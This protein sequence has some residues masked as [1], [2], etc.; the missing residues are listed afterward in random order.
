MA[1]ET[2][3]YSEEIKANPKAILGEDLEIPLCDLK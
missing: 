3:K 2:L 1:E